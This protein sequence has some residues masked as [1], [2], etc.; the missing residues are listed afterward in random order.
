MVVKVVHDTLE[1]KYKPLHYQLYS[2]SLPNAGLCCWIK[3]CPQR[4]KETTDE[5]DEKL[6]DIDSNK[7]ILNWSKEKNTLVK[8]AW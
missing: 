6:N 7:K 2:K 3:F 5:D 8:G 1:K 4:L